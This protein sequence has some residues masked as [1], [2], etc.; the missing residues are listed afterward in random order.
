MRAHA[1]CFEV[2]YLFFSK[3]KPMS[4]SHLFIFYTK[5]KDGCCKGIGFDTEDNVVLKDDATIGIYYTHYR[6]D[7]KALCYSS[8]LQSN[9]NAQKE[10]VTRYLRAH[11]VPDENVTVHYARANS[12]NCPFKVSPKEIKKLMG[13]RKC[14]YLYRVELIKK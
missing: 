1:L 9:L 8:Y 4:Y 11:G 2:Y 12:K 14:N 6:N 3:G 10:N 7:Y 5:T 13:K